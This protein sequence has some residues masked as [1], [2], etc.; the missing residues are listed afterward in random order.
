MQQ[1]LG[2]HTEEFPRSD[3]DLARYLSR[4]ATDSPGT[5][6]GSNGGMNPLE[7]RLRPTEPTPRK[8][9]HG[10]VVQVLLQNLQL[11][12]WTASQ[13][14]EPSPQTLT[15]TKP[16]SRPTFASQ[17]MQTNVPAVR[18]TMIARPVAMRTTLHVLLH[19]D[20]SVLRGVGVVG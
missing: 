15:P 19:A 12:H 3:L 1:H 5:F 13:H 17:P 6:H 8:Q 11:A 18:F 20:W 9:E 2:N 16:P 4:N 10:F 7:G 14:E